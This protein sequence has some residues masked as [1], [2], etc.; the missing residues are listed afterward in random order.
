MP[1]LEWDRVMAATPEKISED[2]V[3]EFY[4]NFIGYN[5][6]DQSDPEK[7]RKLFEVSKVVMKTKHESIEETIQMFEKETAEAQKKEE[8]QNKEIEKLKKKMAEVEKFGPETGG[9]TSRGAGALRDQVTDLE[10]RKEELEQDVKDLQRDLASEKRAAEK[11]SERISELEK[12]QKDMRDENDQLRQ[13]ISDYKMQMQSQKDN[14]VSKRGDEIEFR[15]KLMKKNHEMAEAME[16]LQNLTDANEMYAKK[17]E[18]LQTKME[19]AILDMDRTREDNL[20]LRNTLQEIDKDTDKVRKEN[21]VLKAQVQDLNEQV[22]SKTD[23]DDAIMVAVNNKIEEWKVILSEKDEAIVEFQEQAIHLREQLIAANMDADK[24]SVA[25]LT[26]VIKEKDKQIEDLTD[27]I[28]AYVDE[29][30]ANAAVVED[31]RTE[32]HKSGAG[33]GDRQLHRIRELQ[34]DL[35]YERKKLTEVNNDIKVAERD[36]REKDKELSDAL[37]RMRKYEAGEYGLAEAVAEIKEGNNQIKVRDRQI[38]ELTQY[39]NK[40]E[41][42]INDMEE[43]NEDLRYRL[44]LDPRE[45][46][47][48]TQF[49]K[50]KATRKEEEKALNFILQR[51]VE[52]LEDERVVLKK[53]IRKLAQQTGQRAV[54]LGLTAEDMMAVADFQEELKATRV[55][56]AEA[57]STGAQIRREVESEETQLRHREAGDEFRE[58]MREMDKLYRENAQFKAKVEQLENDNRQLEGGLKEVLENLQKYKPDEHGTEDQPMQFP[59]LERMLAAIE[60]KSVIGKYDT[61]LYLKAQV[62]NLQGRNDEIRAELRETRHEA[63]KARM[64]VEKSLEKIEQ[65]EADLKAAKESG[66]GPGV[67]QKIPLPDSMAITSSEVISSLNEHL[68]TVLQELSLKEACMN[69]MENALDNYKRKFA[70]LRHQQ[71]LMYADYIKD[72][73]DWEKET[74]TIRQQMKTMDASQEENKVRLQEFDRLID[75]LS[76]DEPEVRRRLSEM[77]RRI[78]VLRVNEKALTRRYNISE[79]VE[80][81]LRKEI[82]HYKNEMASMETSVSERLGYLQRFKDMATFKV[83]ALQKALE[84]SVPTEDLEITNKKFL[85]LTEKY[86]DGLEKENS[87]VSKADVITGLEEEVTRLTENND[88]LKKTLEMEKEKLHALEAAMEDLHR[89]GIT[90]GTEVRSVTDGDVI[91]ISKRITTLEMKELNERQR[92]EHSVRMYEQQKKVLQGLD[93]RNKDLESKFSEITQSNLELQRI[94]RDLRDELSKSVTKAVSD[95]DRKRITQL[96]E[97]E[98]TLRNEISKLKEVCEVATS[99][100]KTLETLQLS[101]EK[102]NTSLRQ[103]LLDFQMQSDEKTIIGKLHRHIVQLQVSEGTSVRRLE[104]SKKRVTKL[105]AQILRMDQKLDDKNQTMV[106]NKAEAQNKAKHLKRNLQEMRLQYAGAIP[107]SKQEKF[108]INMRKL[109]HDK[110]NLEL[111]LKQAREKRDTVENKLSAMELQHKSLQDLIATLKDGRGAAKVVEWHSKMD[112]VRLEELKQK[113]LNVKLQ[114]QIHYLEGMVRTSEAT[115]SDLEGEIV[116]QTQEYEEKQLR[117]EQREVELERTIARLEDQVSQIAG[118]ASKFEEAVGTLPDAKLPVAN[119]LEE[120]ISTIRGNVKIIL[121]TQAENK[122]LKKRNSE[123]EKQLHE[124]DKTILARDRLVADLRLRLPASADRDEMILKTTSKI[125]ESMAKPQKDKEYE[126]EHSIRIA[127]ATVSSLQ[128][129]LQQKEETIAKYQQLL[130]QA[131]EDMLEMNRRHD[132]DLKDMQHKLHLNT[133][134]AFNKFK[135]AARDLMAKQLAHPMSSKQLARLN[136]LEDLLVEQDN[137]MA[138]MSEKIRQRDEEIASLRSR[139]QVDSRSHN[140]ERERMTEETRT[141]IQARE[142]EVEECHRQIDH[143]KKE[144]DLLRQEIEVLKEQNNRAPTTTMKNLVDRLKNQLAHKEKQHQALSKALTE[145]RADMVQQAQETVTQQA[146]ESSQETNIQKLIDSHT[147]EMADQIED[148]QNEGDRLKKEVKK[149]KDQEANLQTEL[150]DT[151]EEMTR[152][153]RNLHR[154]KGDKHRLEQ[155]VE[156]LEKKVERMS[157]MKTQKSGDN[158]RQQEYDEMRRRVRLLEDELKRKQQQPEKPYERQKEAPAPPKVTPREKSDEIIKWEESK[159]W[160]KTVEKMKGKVRE[161]EAEVEKMQRMSQMLRDQ[162]DRAI[163]EKEGLERKNFNLQRAAAAAPAGP[164]GPSG[165]HGKADHQMEALRTKNFQLQEEVSSLRQ[166][167]ALG[168]DAAFQELQVKNTYLSQQL[169][170]MEQVVAHKS[171]ITSAEPSQTV[172]PFGA[173]EYQDF[174]EKNQNL[175]RQVLTLSEENI[176]LKF[177]SEQLRKDTPRLKERIKDLQ[178]YVEALKLENS[179]LG[180]NSTT[181]SLDSSGSS[182]I[183]RIGDSGKS[184]RELE[185]TVALLKKVVERVQIENEQLKRGSNAATQLTSLRLENEGLKSQL[186][187]LRQKMGATLSERYTSTQ[188]GTAKMMSDYEKMR[189]DLIKEMETNEK[190]RVD[191][192]NLELQKE[193]IGAQLSEARSISATGGDRPTLQTTMDSKGWKSA[194]VTRMYEGK[195]KDLEADVSKKNKMLEDVKSLLKEAAEREQYLLQEREGLK[196]Q[197]AILERFPADGQRSEGGAARENQQL[198]LKVDRLENEKKELNYQLQLLRQGGE[199]PSEEMLAKIGAYDRLMNENVELKMNLK[200]IETDKNRQRLETE[201]LKKELDNFGPDFFEEVEDLKYNYKQSVEK[202]VLY[203]EKLQQLSQQLG[204]SITIPGI[205]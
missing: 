46:L 162:L 75:T 156:D 5:P 15:D 189:K 106:H 153:D 97:V 85:K 204:I 174:F 150:D 117:W 112:A 169:E 133:D 155:E 109:H 62:D 120:A 82:N 154:V 44:G 121:D 27:K 190:L 16:E 17:I 146:H 138:A 119:Q 144:A 122:A 205:H 115:T 89:R 19:E 60:A 188:K 78:T 52:K 25:A 81:Q 142:R 168:K 58:N 101:R 50:N 98:V 134:T 175:Q 8:S 66:G 152:K 136:Q 6:S 167:L 201:R 42:K 9:G 132:K 67:F 164:T 3:E 59:T 102:E 22:Q 74:E 128:A 151:R 72:K 90:E 160:Q 110:T 21:E 64:E 186:D 107:L 55:K 76:K 157:T 35:E 7:L 57:T 161:R 118:A 43:E 165:A 14:L 143:H 86:R 135:D 29:M 41:M 45:P 31:L 68:V 24:A 137:A 177:E 71:G 191:I 178:K 158:A 10:R 181:R 176:E 183:R 61:S 83:S 103:Q 147:K 4:E 36:A 123:L 192:R 26:T 203:E 193:Q 116:R 40:V 53:K 95:A 170:Q 94:E 173:K 56:H 77:T 139:L 198:R 20:K 159:K 108:T 80:G 65:L 145:L 11:Y 166:Q 182:G 184:T 23:A 12:I 100:V 187:E 54:A 39:I 33:P 200:T 96:E 63:N 172:S 38:E 179:Q 140:V 105:E 202:N 47:D 180:G 30:E 88:V 69:K 194:V 129:R 2:D 79:E 111:E 148:L 104:E 149:R 37:E 113:R 1:P 195:L 70:V 92:A 197:L 127:Q 18:E 34:T 171:S 91:T 130:K 99:Q 49:R 51:E 73:K 32:L 28:K 199:Q 48:L 124:S 93:E 185:K 141:G 163:R 87:L 114:Q 84:D 131:R 196:Q 13:D 125:T 126:S